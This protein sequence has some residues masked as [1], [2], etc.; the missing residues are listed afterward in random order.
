MGLTLV[1]VR[2]G[3][4]DW[5]VARRYGGDPHIR[6]NETGRY[7]ARQLAD[8]ADGPYASIWMSPFE[9]C[10]ETARLMD[11]DARVAGALAEFDFGELNGMRW[12]DLDRSTQRAIVSFDGFVAPGG[13]SVAEFGTRIDV[14]VAGLVPGR[15]LLITHGGV[16]RHLMRRVGRDDDVPAGTSTV[17]EFSRR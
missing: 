6:L 13:E 4:T 9:R 12:D 16:I 2:H 15:H 3:Q 8:L 10:R 17:V 7:Q 11:V 5:N 14:F 1:L